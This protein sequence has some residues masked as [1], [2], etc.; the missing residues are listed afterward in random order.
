MYDNN[1]KCKLHLLFHLGQ[2]GLDLRGPYC[3]FSQCFIENVI[4][5]QRFQIPDNTLRLRK[6]WPQ[7]RNVPWEMALQ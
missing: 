1:G 3:H 4:C 7:S 2:A 6:A 5:N